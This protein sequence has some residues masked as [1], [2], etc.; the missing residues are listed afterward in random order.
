MQLVCI[1]RGKSV[2]QWAGCYIN[3]QFMNHLK[4]PT[5]PTL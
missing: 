5:V 1:K 3:D 4:T 2:S